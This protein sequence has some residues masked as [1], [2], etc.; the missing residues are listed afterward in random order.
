MK[1]DLKYLGKERKRQ[2]KYYTKTKELLKKELKERR[3]AVELRVK[4]HRQ[5]L[6]E[7]SSL[8]ETTTDMSST[9]SPN[10]RTSFIVS[11]SF[12]KRGESSRKRK[13]QSQN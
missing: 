3:E 13:R 11:M 8:I 4:K 2:R 1:E 10:Q 12:P 7:E 9:S 6:K 5:S